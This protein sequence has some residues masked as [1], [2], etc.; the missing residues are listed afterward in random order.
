MRLVKLWVERFQC[1]E[2]AEVEFGQG[3]NVLYG[4]N[5]LGK[6][7][8]AWA[9][10]SVLLLQHSSTAHERFVSWHGGGEPAVTL[11]LTDDTHRYWRIQKVFSAGTAGRSLLES[12]KDGRS[13][14]QEATGRNVDERVRQL[15]RWG[16][17]AKLGGRGGPQ[18]LPASFLTHVL[19]AD[20][21]DVR[22]I[23]FDASLTKDPDESGRQRL[24]EALGALAQDPRFKA[25]LNRAQVQVDRAFTSTGRQKRSA[26]SPF[27]EIAK[28]LEALQQQRDDL[29][30]KEKDTELAEADLQAK[31]TERER[32]SLELE[33]KHEIANR[34]AAALVAQDRRDMVAR[35]LE[36]ETAR[37]ANVNARRADAERIHAELARHE[38]VIRDAGTVQEQLREQVAQ[39]ESER[40]TRRAALDEATTAASHTPSPEQRAHLESV[41]EAIAAATR[42][43]DTAQGEH[44]E[45]AALAKVVATQGVALHHASAEGQSSERAHEA[46]RNEDQIARG[47]L[48]AA[49]DQLREAT[50]GDQARVRALR[51][52][53][54]SKRG[55]EID[56]LEADVAR[57]SERIAACERLAS[58]AAA[59]DAARGAA[60][61]K[62]EATRQEVNEAESGIAALERDQAFLERV[63]RYDD[64]VAARG[65]LAEAHQAAEEATRQL[66]TA[67]RLRAEANALRASLR[68]GVP[69][70]VAID[71]LQRLLNELRLGEAKLGA[72]SVQVRPARALR[73]EIERDGVRQPA[74]ELAEPTVLSAAGRVVIAIEGVGDFDV[75]GGDD[76]VRSEVETL[77]ARWQ[78]QAAPVLR[79]CQA[80]TVDEV[81]QLRRDADRTLAQLE[82][83]LRDAQTHEQLAQQRRPDNLE[84]LAQEVASIEREL[85]ADIAALAAHHATFGTSVRRDTTDRI[86]HQKRERSAS[87]AKQQERRESLARQEAAIESL[88]REVRDARSKLTERESGLDAPWPAALERTNAERDRIRLE[89]QQVKTLTEAL[90]S[91][92]GQ[93]EAAA[94]AAI[95]AAEARIAKAASELAEAERGATQA[96]EARATAR[97][98]LAASVDR[99]RTIDGR[100]GRLGELDPDAPVLDVGPWQREASHATARVEALRAQLETLSKSLDAES[101]ARQAAATAARAALNTL[102]AAIQQDRERLEAASHGERTAR[103]QLDRLRGEETRIQIELASVDT[104]ATAARI[105]ALKCELAALPPAKDRYSRAQQ[106]EIEA[107]LAELST[108]QEELKT[109]IERARGGLEKVGGAVVREQAQEIDDAIR[110]AQAEQHQI[111]VEFSAWKLL[112]EALRSSEATEAQHLGRALATPVSDRFRKLTGGRYGAVELDAQLAAQGL[113]AAGHLRDISVLS[114]GTQDQLATLLRLCIAEHVKSSIVL[115][116]HLSQSDPG[117]IA[118]FNNALRT[119]AMGVQIIVIT[120]RPGEL[121]SPEEFPADGEPLRSASGG[122]M[123][124]IALERSIRRFAR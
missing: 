22:K 95:K 16:V 116:D 42:A 54:L 113:H 83:R 106:Q 18:G 50:S 84:P 63:L 2:S 82:D 77:Q 74:R 35:D 52:A 109:A 64:L 88:E 123:R 76:V 24:T 53:E 81:V 15:L 19:L 101:L 110:G 100:C 112:V 25:I 98:A 70:V 97:A 57:R 105:G 17:H 114:A 96:R 27:I 119:A 68:P 45:I 111:E 9:I 91:E 3:L 60:S 115:D 1:I 73:V 86:E 10:R 102:E 46:A 117:R 7:S 124:A 31:H 118:W 8:L 23:L 21:D 72:V 38:Q 34:L 56:A 12:S 48:E 47:V 51:S 30:Q 66:N 121:L 90:A 80:E 78:A 20:Q 87:T 71:K 4:P 58:E 99:A 85:H 122:L 41:R 40:T 104:E 79:A 11:T 89:R 28:R 62:L 49:R 107:R 37:L 36:A 13:F 65:R 108:Q 69:D 6:T 43:A 29:R 59:A 39:L 67:A 55:A 5:D 33:Q 93:G 103:T 32:I 14:T 92:S 94:R 26:D 75:R 61:Q 120:C 44:A